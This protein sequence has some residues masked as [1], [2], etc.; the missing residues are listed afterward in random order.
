MSRRQ[1]KALQPEPSSSTTTP[2]RRSI[3]VKIRDFAF[4]KSDDRHV[5]KGPDVPRPNRTRRYRASTAS[6]SSQSSSSA[7]SS[8]AEEDGKDEGEDQRGSWGAFRWNTLSSHFSWGAGGGHADAPSRTDFERNFDVSSPTEESPERYESEEGQ[9]E[10]ESEDGAAVNEDEPL[11]PG[12]YKALYAFEPE[13]TAEMALDEDQI[14]RVVG[15]GG[16]VGW[17]VVVTAE[18]THA[19]VPESYLELVQ[20]DEDPEAT[21]DA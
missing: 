12:L 18:G 20:L 11:L 14:V 8:A 17:A 9:E 5:G 6:M 15:R 16:G 19:L 10:Y 21:T 13:G 2:K 3:F 7:S 4:V 1:S